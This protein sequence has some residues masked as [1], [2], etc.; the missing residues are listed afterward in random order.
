MSE[1]TNTAFTP[2]IVKYEVGGKTLKLAPLSFKKFRA[3]IQLLGKSLSE[4]AVSGNG[5]VALTKV[6]EILMDRVVE[7]IPSLFDEKEHGFLNKEWIE[8][9]L[10]IAL[11][12]RIMLDAIRVNGVQDF[13][14][15]LRGATGSVLPPP[16]AVK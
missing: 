1:T 10:S 5:E 4:I 12:N 16:P 7:I 8:E 13:L 6:P 9:N 15:G 2:E 14:R 3:L 11:A